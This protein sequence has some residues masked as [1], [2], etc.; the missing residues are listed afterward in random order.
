MKEL[1]RQAGPDWPNEQFHICLSVLCPVCGEE[2]QD[3]AMAC[4]AVCTDLMVKLAGCSGLY[5]QAM[6]MGELEV[7]PW[8]GVEGGIES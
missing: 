1:V 3:L 2:V 4:E 5:L 6:R 7:A 8:V